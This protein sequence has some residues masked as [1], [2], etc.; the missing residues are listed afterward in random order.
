MDEDVK[1]AA[2]KRLERSI[3]LDELARVE[4]IEV[5][6]EEL[7]NEF[8]QM[9]NEMQYGTDPKKLQKELKSE[10]FANA[11]AM[12]AATRL[13]NRKVLDCLKDI[14]TGKQPKKAAEKKEEPVAEGDAENR[15]R[16]KKQPKKKLLKLKNLP[17]KNRSK[18]R[19]RSKK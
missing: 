15:Q 19:K 17:P 3:V 9:V 5:G 13:L 7:Q 18:P 8:T 10:R 4:K 11:L 2:Q 16:P 1:P 6:N 12:E 14:A